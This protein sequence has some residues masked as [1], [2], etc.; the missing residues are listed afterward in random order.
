MGKPF[1][2]LVGPIRLLSAEKHTKR[3]IIP[4]LSCSE[5]YDN[6]CKTIHF[7][8]TSSIPF[9]QYTTFEAPTLH[10]SATPLKRSPCLLKEMHILWNIKITDASVAIKMQLDVDNEPYLSQQ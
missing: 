2:N 5:K 9:N 3:S 4:G 10:V 6:N 7:D 8:V 1:F